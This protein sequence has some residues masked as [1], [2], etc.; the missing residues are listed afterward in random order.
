MQK[1]RQAS[2][3]FP[4]AAGAFAMKKNAS[5]NR[6]RR[7]TAE[8]PGVRRERALT[9]ERRFALA[10]RQSRREESRRTDERE[11]RSVFRRRLRGASG[12]KAPYT[13]RTRA[14]YRFSREYPGVADRNGFRENAPD[15]RRLRRLRILGVILAVLVFCGSY[16]VARALR[17]VSAQP[18]EETAAAEPA[19]AYEPA[20]RILRVSREELAG[21]TPQRILEK[22]RAAGCNAALFELKDDDGRML[23]Y[24]GETL[25][26]G[27]DGIVPGEEDTFACL[28]KAGVT[29]VGSVSC[30]LDNTA[31][32]YAPEMAVLK[33]GSGDVWKDAA[34]NTR[35]NPFSAAASEYL[36]DVV[37]AA[38][39]AGF[40]MLVLRNV[41]FPAQTGVAPASFPGEFDGTATRSGALLSFVSAVVK[42]AGEAKVALMEPCGAFD[43]AATNSEPLYGGN[44]LATAAGTLCVDARPSLQKRNAVIGDEVFFDAAGLPFPFVLAAGEFARSGMQEAGAEAR[45]FLCVENGESLEKQL[46]AVRL[47]R[48]DGYLVW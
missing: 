10:R 39:G 20:V 44:L 4:L 42:N 28:K 19:A 33:S 30:F 25:L 24:T 8:T 26:P 27:T 17:G 15:R 36:L 6:T 1:I 47:L 41:D 43:A 13:L 32:A 9:P 2:L 18:P 46:D 38:A 31:P 48:A 16:T 40:E 3:F 21:E 22:V 23:L 14:Y 5:E 12:K 29:L 7:K 34:G 35:L 11:K 37:R 45:L